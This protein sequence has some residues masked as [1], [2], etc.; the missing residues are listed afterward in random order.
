MKFSA[1]KIPYVNLQEQWLEERDDLL[2]IMDRVFTSAQFVWARSYLK[3]K[4]RYYP[5]PSTLKLTPYGL[6]PQS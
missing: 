5:I 2:P 1:N 6:H 3:H 4:F